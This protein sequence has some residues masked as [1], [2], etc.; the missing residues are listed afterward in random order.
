VK[1]ISSTVY[2]TTFTLPNRRDDTVNLNNWGS[3]RISSAC[4]CLIGTVSTTTTT[5]TIYTGQVSTILSTKVVGVTTTL[6]TSTAFVT[7]TVQ[8]VST[9][10]AIE[11]LYCNVY[12]DPDLPSLAQY[13]IGSAFTTPDLAGCAVACN[14]IANCQSYIWGYT[15]R[16]CSLYIVQLT[17]ENTQPNPL[18]LPLGNRACPNFLSFSTTL[19]SSS[20]TACSTTSSAARTGANGEAL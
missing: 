18:L 10:T 11:T 3:S 9:S 16:I 2:V 15:S 1:V 17:Q 8:A 4:S 13:G 12:A 19:T 14:A 20:S 6:P 7:S 5:E